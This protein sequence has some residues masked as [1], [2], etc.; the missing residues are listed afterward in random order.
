MPGPFVRPGLDELRATV[1]LAVP[2]VVAR[3]GFMLMGVVDTVMVGHLSAEALASVALGHLYLFACSAFGMGGLMVVDPLVAQSV[4]AGDTDG[5]RRAVQRGVLIALLSTLPTALVMIPGE[6]VLTLLGQ[7]VTV[8]P[9]AADYVRICILSLPAFFVFIVLRQT[10]QALQKVRGIVL[11]TVVANL[12]NLGLDW[13]LIFGVGRFEGLGVLGSAWATT[14]SR[15]VMLLALLYLARSELAPMLA[16]LEREAL[17]L[18]PV[19]RMVR[20]GL[21][22]GAQLQLEFAAFAVIALLMGW[23]GT[24]AMA[25]H[26]VAINLASLTFMVPLGVSMAAAVRVGHAVGRGDP[27]G[28]RRAAA[29]SLLCGGG[30]MAL[31]GGA[32]ILAPGLLAAIYTSAPDVR[33]LAASLIPVAG[34][35]Q[36][37]DGVQIVAAGVLRGLGDI[38][39]PMLINVVGFW[40]VGMPVSLVL[41]FPVGLGPVGLWWGLA[42]GLGAVGALLLTRA[43]VR[44][45]GELARMVV[46]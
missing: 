11:A 24:V 44:L 42:A 2:V 17:R 33:L 39:V 35:F 27:L 36:V 22:I 34:V 6:W 20:L 7:P 40:L 4:G 9:V 5:A 3:V 29:A 18:A 37:F 45:S 21:P 32:F 15:W 13:V 8:A 16:R 1:R 46:E 43:T 25:A 41:A 10:L 38:R 14:A 12:A 26:Q 31:C 30:F 23:I 28:A 19:A